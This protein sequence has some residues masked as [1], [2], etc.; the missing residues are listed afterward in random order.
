ML[1]VIVN[2]AG[3]YTLSGA[4]APNGQLLRMRDPDELRTRL[5]ARAGQYGKLDDVEVVLRPDTNTHWEALAPLY[6]AALRAKYQKVSFA[7]T[8]AK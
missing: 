6:D 3:D 4:V 8:G 1:D 5:I 7:M 2:E